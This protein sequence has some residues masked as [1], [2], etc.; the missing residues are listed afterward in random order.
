MQ[1]KRDI[2]WTGMHAVDHSILDCLIMPSVGTDRLTNGAYPD[3]EQ[4]E[5][6]L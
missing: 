5:Q 2:I 6:E 3:Q 4:S 1:Y